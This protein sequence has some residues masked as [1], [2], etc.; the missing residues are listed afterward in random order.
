MFTFK[1]IQICYLKNCCRCKSFLIYLAYIGRYG[2]LI[3][4]IVREVLLKLK[5]KNRTLPDHLVE[6]N[7]LEYIEELLDINSNDHVRFIII[8]GTGGIG[9]STL[10]SVI[11]NRFRSKFD[12]CS[13]L[14]DV[15]SHRLLDMQKKLLSETLGSNSTQEMYDTNDGIDRITRGLGKAKFLVVVD[16]VDEK[17]K[18]ENLVGSY[19]WFGSGSRIIVTL[20]DIRII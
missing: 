15:Q 1:W 3:K 20:R 7:D 12:Y 14:E 10:A 19:D 16:N 18:L 17:K 11:F 2:E 13:F 4:L 5:G 6:M 9:K 8:H